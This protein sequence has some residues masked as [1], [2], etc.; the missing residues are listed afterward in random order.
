M[1]PYGKR[2][3]DA[4]LGVFSVFLSLCMTHRELAP[5]TAW[6]AMISKTPRPHNGTSL[7][8]ICLLTVY[9]PTTTGPLIPRSSWQTATQP[10]VLCAQCPQQLAAAVRRVR[11][12]FLH[13][14]ATITLLLLYMFVFLCILRG[15]CTNVSF[16]WTEPWT[17]AR[18]PPRF[19]H[20]SFKNLKLSV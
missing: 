16:G 6:P 15:F 7:I 1:Q 12:T 18:L 14:V 8:S 3:W 13:I 10:C 20:F 9:T 2:C 4:L 11:R 5:G 19:R 17:L